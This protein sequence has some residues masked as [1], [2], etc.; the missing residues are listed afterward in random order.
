MWL[1]KL[2]VHARQPHKMSKIDR[3]EQ[4]GWML[5]HERLQIYTLNFIFKQ[6]FYKSPIQ[7]SFELFVKREDNGRSSKLEDN[8]AVAKM[9]TEFGKTSIN[10][11]GIIMWN[12]LPYKIKNILDCLTLT[13][14][15]GIGSWI[16][17]TTG[18]HILVRLHLFYDIPCYTTWTWKAL[19]AF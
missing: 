2:V 8:F 14:V 4:L 6:I 18:W 13:Q 10:Y 1:L 15:S 5:F 19:V 7:K 9:E 11:A 12:S 17:E 3:L 16:S